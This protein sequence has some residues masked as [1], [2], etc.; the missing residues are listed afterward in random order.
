ML[1]LFARWIDMR[2][3]AIPDI[4]SV[5]A[6]EQSHVRL[7]LGLALL[8]LGTGLLMMVLSFFAFVFKSADAYQDFLRSIGG[9]GGIGGAIVTFASVF[10]IKELVERRL[11]LRKLH[12]LQVVL[13][14][15]KMRTNAPEDHVERTYDLLWEMYRKVIIG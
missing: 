1:L 13:A 8:V 10:P 12:D 3:T 15:L 6:N 5:I 7:F 9:I 4:S 11:R 14:Q 2:A